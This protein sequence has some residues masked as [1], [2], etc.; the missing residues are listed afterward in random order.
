M[1]K[2]T[3]SDK[4]SKKSSKKA[5]EKS[6]QPSIIAENHTFTL[7]IPWKEVEQGWQKA[8]VWAQQQIKVDGFRKGKV[9]L[10]LVE[11]NVDRQHLVQRTVEEVVPPAYQE[12]IRENKLTPLT[13]PD[14]RAQSVDQGEDWVFEGAL[15]QRPEIDITGY[16]KMVQEIKKNSDLWNEKTAKKSDK[17]S[18]KD[19]KSEQAKPELT[20]EQ[21]KD[22]QVGT[23]V[24]QLLEKIHVPVPELLLRRETE[25][26]LH[27]LE[28]ELEHMQMSVA[29]FLEKSGKKLEDIQQDYAARALGNLQVELLLGSIIRTKD[30]KVEADE[31][32]EALKKRYTTDENG[33]QPQITTEDVTYVQSVLLKQ[34]ALDHLLDL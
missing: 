8:L 31:V 24:S 23:L 9:P 20:A 22:A 32:A 17:K 15:A 4:S 10:K 3:A 29:D 5:E 1:A 7:T 27:R 13:E 14:I 6:S 28:H 26:Q 25:Y 16:E 11:Q 33:K 18:A 21:K 19:E 12:Y 30:I 2:A 34:K